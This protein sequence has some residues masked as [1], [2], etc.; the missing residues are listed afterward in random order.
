MCFQKSD[1]SQVQRRSR[2]HSF[3]G[4]QL[5]SSG[6]SIP[7]RRHYD[8][9]THHF[10][11]DIH[12]VDGRS[13]KPLVRRMTTRG[14]HH[15]QYVDEQWIHDL[16]HYDQ[17][18]THKSMSDMSVKPAVQDDIT[19]HI[20]KSKSDDKSDVCRRE[21]QE[22]VPPPHPSH[23][24][25]IKAKSNTKT[26]SLSV[27][28]QE[29][30]LDLSYIDSSSDQCDGS[31]QTWHKNPLLVKRTKRRRD[32]PVSAEIYYTPSNSPA[33]QTHQTWQD[34]SGSPRLKSKDEVVK[35][36]RRSPRRLS[37]PNNF[38]TSS[39]RTT[40]RSAGSTPRR[41]SD[42]IQEKLDKFAELQKKR[43]DLEST[44]EESVNN[45]HYSQRKQNTIQEQFQHALRPTRGR[46]SGEISPFT[47]LTPQH[48]RKATMHDDQQ[49]YEGSKKHITHSQD[50]VRKTESKNLAEPI[51]TV[52]K[53]SHRHGASQHE[54][55]KL[56][57]TPAHVEQSKPHPVKAEV[58]YRG[59]LNS[60]SNKSPANIGKSQMDFRKV[61]E[62]LTH[63]IPDGKFYTPEYDNQTPLSKPRNI[64]S[65]FENI[66]DGIDLSTHLSL[67]DKI[68][69]A[70]FKRMCEN[71]PK[72]FDHIRMMHKEISKNS[73]DPTEVKPQAGSLSLVSSKD[74][75]MD[76]RQRGYTDTSYKPLK[77]S[78]HPGK[79]IIP[80]ADNYHN[81]SNLPPLNNMSPPSSTSQQSDSWY[82]QKSFQEQEPQSPS[83]KMDAKM[84]IEE[85]Q[86]KFA[87]YK[88]EYKRKKSEKESTSGTSGDEIKESGDDSNPKMIPPDEYDYI[89]RKFHHQRQ[90]AIYETATPSD[91]SRTHSISS[92]VSHTSGYEPSHDQYLREMKERKNV[93]LMHRGKSKQT[94]LTDD[95][96]PPVFDDQMQQKNKHL[97]ARNVNHLYHT[98]SLSGSSI[99]NIDNSLHSH[100]NPD[101]QRTQKKYFPS[102][103][104]SMSLDS[105]DR[106][107]LS[108]ASEKQSVPLTSRSSDMPKSKYFPSPFTNVIQNKEEK[109]IPKTGPQHRYH[110][111]PLHNTDTVQAQSMPS[112]IPAVEKY[113]PREGKYMSSSLMQPN[114]KHDEDDS[115]CGPSAYDAPISSSAKDISVHKAQQPQVQRRHF[116]PPVT[117][118]YQP[119]NKQ[120]PSDARRERESKLYHRRS[121]DPDNY[122]SSH[123]QF[124]TKTPGESQT[125]YRVAQVNNTEQW[126]CAKE[127]F[128]NKEKE[129]MPKQHTTEFAGMV[130]GQEMRNFHPSSGV[131]SREQWNSQQGIAYRKEQTQ[132]HDAGKDLAGGQEEKQFHPEHGYR[133]LSEH[134]NHVSSGSP[135]HILNK[136]PDSN[137]FIH[138]DRQSEQIIPN[139]YYQKPMKDVARPEDL[140][141]RDRRPIYEQSYGTLEESGFFRPIATYPPSPR[142][143]RHDISTM[144]DNNEFHYKDPLQPT[145]KPY[146]GH[147]N[148]IA[149]HSVPYENRESFRP[150]KSSTNINDTHD[151][152]I[153]KQKTSNPVEGKVHPMKQQVHHSSPN[154]SYDYGSKIEARQPSTPDYYQIRNDHI[155]EQ[156]QVNNKHESE[157]TFLSND[158]QG[159]NYPNYNKKATMYNNH[160]LRDEI[161]PQMI[162]YQNR[163]NQSYIFERKQTHNQNVST[164]PQMSAIEYDQYNDVAETAKPYPVEIMSHMPN[165]KDE[166]RNISNKKPPTPKRDN[167]ISKPK[168]W[169]YSTA[170]ASH[171]G[172]YDCMTNRMIEEENR[173]NRQHKTSE[174]KAMASRKCTELS[175]SKLSRE[176]LQSSDTP[177]LT[178]E[179]KVK[180]YCE[181]HRQSQATAQYEKYVQK[182]QARYRDLKS[183]NSN[184][185]DAGGKIPLRRSKSLPRD[186][187]NSMKDRCNNQPSFDIQVTLKRSASQATENRPTGFVLRMSKSEDDLRSCHTGS[188]EMPR[189]SIKSIKDKLYGNAGELPDSKKETE[190]VNVWDRRDRKVSK[191]A[192]DVFNMTDQSLPEYDKPVPPSS[193]QFGEEEDVRLSDYISYKDGYRRKTTTIDDV[194]TD[195]EQTYENLQLDSDEWS[196]DVERTDHTERPN[197]PYTPVEHREG[198]VNVKR[199]SITNLKKLEEIQMSVENPSLEYAK[200]WL[201]TGN[202]SEVLGEDSVHQVSTTYPINHSESQSLTSELRI[203]D[204]TSSLPRKIAD[205]MAVRKIQPY[206]PSVS[207]SAAHLGSYLAQSLGGA[208]SPSL[209]RRSMSTHQAADGVYDDIPYRT[210]QRCKS[211][212]GSEK[213]SALLGAPSP[214]STDYLKERTTEPGRGRMRVR[215][216]YDADKYH[217][218]MAY[219]KLRKDVNPISASLP[220]AYY[221]MMH[222]SQNP[223]RRSLSLERITHRKQADHARPTS[224]QRSNSVGPSEKRRSVEKGVA[225]ILEVFNNSL[226]NSQS[227]PDLLDKSA[228]A[229]KYDDQGD[230]VSDDPKYCK[231]SSKSKKQQT[232]RTVKQRHE[233]KS[234]L[235][236]MKSSA[237]SGYL[238]SES[239]SHS[240]SGPD[241]HYNRTTPD[242]AFES[243]DPDHSKHCDSTLR[244]PPCYVDMHVK[245]ENIGHNSI[246]DPQVSSPKSSAHPLRADSSVDKNKS[247][248]QRQSLEHQHKQ[249]QHNQTEQKL[250]TAVISPLSSHTSENQFPKYS[251]QVVNQSIPVQQSRVVQGLP[252]QSMA[253]QSFTQQSM[254]VKDLTRQNVKSE[255]M[256]VPV[257]TRQNIGTESISDA[258]TNSDISAGAKVN[259]E[260]ETKV[261][262]RKP[263]FK[264][265]EKLRQSMA[266]ASSAIVP[267]TLVSRDSEMIKRTQADE[268]KVTKIDKLTKRGPGTWESEIEK[269]TVIEQPNMRSVHQNRAKTTMEH[270]TMQDDKCKMSVVRER[271]EVKHVGKI[272]MTVVEG[273]TEPMVRLTGAHQHPSLHV[274][275]PIKSSPSPTHTPQSRMSH[276]M[277]HS[278]FSPADLSD[279]EMTDATDIT[280]DNLVRT[281]MGR[282]SS[283]ETLDMS[284]DWDRV[285]DKASSDGSQ[286]AITN[287]IADKKLQSSAKTMHTFHEVSINDDGRNKTDSFSSSQACVI[288]TNKTEGG[289]KVERTPS[290]K[291]LL[292]SFE[293]KTNFGIKVSLFKQPSAEDLRSDGSADTRPPRPTSRKNFRE[294]WGSDPNLH[295]SSGRQVS[296]SDSKRYVDPGSPRWRR[297]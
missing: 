15:N 290:F 16:Y 49:E 188:D 168:D 169:Q 27:D 133:V 57:S 28:K 103:M 182:S 167:Q 102:P 93:H 239:D 250:V 296:E 17:V 6:H 92:T 198:M 61:E 206:P 269:E 221:E 235:K 164:H 9:N 258:V 69:P 98:P 176:Q 228:F 21:N 236:L 99:S 274:P 5:Q 241:L 4:D 177:Y 194:L 280:L 2:P 85:E 244:I 233:L 227:A 253:V 179:D 249:E 37:A 32:R 217:D 64:S 62:G 119:D 66:Y 150:Y 3:H 1:D 156:P 189:V 121:W 129:N 231:V 190:L 245:T 166:Q 108:T 110:L 36:N 237:D 256:T 25:H 71:D 270:H 186:S 243:D 252:K 12:D 60:H 230:L 264:I 158:K 195:L 183:K 123:H 33:S 220:D 146:D 87:D 161:S 160:N 213:G 116:S 191:I 38:G 46:T 26:E 297:Y 238:E 276:R 271:T 83:K 84:L 152:Q 107:D 42:L 59:Y 210:V 282:P 122:Q 185:E 109:P 219:R 157:N 242:G 214:T 216:D 154:V 29:L 170:Y 55:I 225:H 91:H 203:R 13:G 246:I 20:L 145:V 178:Y 159:M 222:G 51:T 77:R 197:R 286:K 19:P 229:E 153:P 48:G 131:A 285:S 151:L 34:D 22:N 180:S 211:P 35:K 261:E 114:K 138:T 293:D 140:R 139:K 149:D 267:A 136:K 24:T 11:P 67:M 287:Y 45:S 265:P 82:A 63:S 263:I 143:S 40:P 79:I 278:P 255:S 137:E 268:T 41:N 204:N 81:R 163:G 288:D 78:S 104:H 72:I 147:I 240:S 223:H 262:P 208:Q 283:R 101:G 31:P 200:R 134:E 128:E 148:M 281:N 272:R 192:G 234:R 212:G 74:V 44:S 184:C 254:A 47:R 97:D 130:H 259:D 165:I 173:K 117:Q 54:F 209:D 88:A 56:Q 53:E 141:S 118:S 248:T 257:I 94:Y 144:Q 127:V 196:K 172:E 8:W 181:D 132:Y 70:E 75:E 14:S 155:S 205:D 113:G 52:H 115:P 187:S 275:W 89:L 126:D 112:L 95:A 106:S 68:N 224:L 289:K 135:R 232:P 142:S 7:P 279:G 10:Y 295:T 124:V 266:A 125:P 218:D 100:L 105:L 90:D 171:D 294:V 58:D 39:P 50:D 111:N 291:E 207:G 174:N 162:S 23:I 215:A 65:S 43:Q 18:D 193:Q 260:G 120:Q 175:D 86:R 73:S 292:R 247:Q 80:D 251:K 30:Q 277:R 284:C 226:D 202:S 273:Q 76:N 96:L 201:S 199:L